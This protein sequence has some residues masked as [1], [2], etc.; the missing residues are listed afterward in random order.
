MIETL[1]SVASLLASYGL[2]LMAN[3]L[4]STLIGLRARLEGFDE[5]ITGLVMSGYYVGLLSGAVLAPRIVARVGHI[6]AFAT[7]APIMSITALAHIMWVNPFGW[8]L[9]RAGSGF[10]MAGMI[11]VTES[12][13]N[14]RT[15][16]RIRGQV[17]AMYMITN[18]FC[19]GLGQFLLPLSDPGEFYLFCLVSILLS[20][21]LVPVLM[22]R[23]VAPVPKAP[24]RG[25][26]I[27][28]FRAAP[29]GI[30]GAMCNGMLNSSFQ[31]MGPVYAQSVGLSITQISVFMGVATLG[32]LT[33][34]WP[35]GW[36]SDRL[37]RRNLLAAVAWLTAFASVGILAGTHAGGLLLF[38]SAAIYGS[39]AN[40]LYSLA[41]AHANDRAE[42]GETVKVASAMLLAFGIGAIL[43]PLLSGFTMKVFGP[44][45]L[46]EQAAVVA[47]F[48][49]VYAIYRQLR[50]PVQPEPKPFVA[51]PTAQYSS[52]ELD[53]AVRENTERK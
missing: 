21:A 7:F 50:R 51:K 10:C 13:L 39:V 45:G 8:T 49:G 24:E 36:L 14:G 44:S 40:T 53:R 22:T 43:G 35:M 37:D 19:A 12:W 29:V 26:F 30:V 48:L 23:A 27:A 15:D 42:E 6:R 5:Q 38:V 52:G 2:L 4:F 16:N 28:V 20:L 17:L 41:S 1:K 11:M 18:Y 31:S 46:F 34:Q 3:G 33:L 9:M 32:G 47:V 25:A